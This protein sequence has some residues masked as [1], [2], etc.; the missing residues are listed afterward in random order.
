MSQNE[1]QHYI[2]PVSK[3]LRK[4]SEANQSL[5]EIESLEDLLPRLME[6][7]KEV[8]AA[9]ASILF[10]YNSENRSLGIVSIK[11]DRFGD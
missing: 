6:L 4:L 7:T 1:C 10:L 3:R 11:D 2:E 5:A 9:E 8:T